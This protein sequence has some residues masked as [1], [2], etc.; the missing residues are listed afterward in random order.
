MAHGFAQLCCLQRGHFMLRNY[1]V[2]SAVGG[3]LMP[4][5]SVYSATLGLRCL[6][7]AM[8]EFCEGEIDKLTMGLGDKWTD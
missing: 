3:C 8:L 4:V 5:S 2:N 1:R 6:S 7:T